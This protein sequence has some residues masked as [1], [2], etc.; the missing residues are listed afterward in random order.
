MSRLA[1]LFYVGCFVVFASVISVC[2]NANAK[3]QV[4]SRGN[5]EQVKKANLGKQWLMVLWSV[6]CPACFKELALLKQIHQSQE[7]IA[8]VLV[9]ADDNQDVDDERNKIIASYKLSSLPN[10]YFADD[11]G[12][13]S[14]YIIDSNWYGELPRSYFVSAE[15]KFHGKSGLIDEQLL[16]KWL[17]AN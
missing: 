7:N 10:Y 6:D 12:D 8:V 15:G 14:R 3:S 9:N 16:R 17:L 5:F 13:E 1:Y 4:F 2:A 11:T